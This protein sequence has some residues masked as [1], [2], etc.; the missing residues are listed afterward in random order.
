MNKQKK[1]LLIAAISI[2]VYTLLGFFVLPIVMKDQI[3]KSV[4]TLLG[5]EPTIER[6][7]FNPFSFEIEINNFVLPEVSEPANSQARLALGRLKINLDLW[8]L[9]KK[10]IRLQSFSIAD[11]SGSFRIN[12]DSG[13]NWELNTIEKISTELPSEKKSRPWILNLVKL[14]IMNTSFKFSDLTHR[15]PLELPLGPIN[16]SASHISTSLDSQSTLNKI[17]ILFAEDGSLEIEGTAGLK[18]ASANISYSFTRLPLDFLSSYLSDYSTLQLKQAFATSRGSLRYNPAGIEFNANLQIQDLD[19]IEEASKK[20]AISLGLLDIKN[21]NF[22]SRPLTAPTLLISEVMLEKLDTSLILRK[23]GTLNFKSYRRATPKKGKENNKEKKPVQYNI[24]K[25]KLTGSR[26]AYSDQQIKPGFSAQIDRLT[27]EFSPI[28]NKPQQKIQV[29]LSGRV[30][31]QGKFNAS[32]FIVSPPGRPM[33]NLDVNFANIE[34]TTFTPY[35]GKFAGYEISK[36][37]MFLNLNY[38]LTNNIIKGSNNLV[39][40]QFTLGSAVESEASDLLPVKFALAL[41]KDRDGKIKINLP[42]EGD[43][44]SPDFNFSELLWTAFKNMIFNIAAAPFDFLKGLLGGGENLDLILFESGTGILSAG[45]SEKLRSLATLLQDRPVLVV[46]VQ[47]STQP[48][49]AET[50]KKN[51]RKREISDDE[52]KK[53]GTL[54]GQLVQNEL[55]ALGIAAERIFLL[56][57]GKLESNEKLPRTSLFLKSK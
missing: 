46:E 53:L 55:V 54:R 23:D 35:S 36:G 9:L 34:L 40:D 37:K 25:I 44:N 33:L 24:Q 45:Q 12:A 31:A 47:G 16:V 15:E 39:L 4:L 2:G 26:L 38:Q 48:E 17:Q 11:T 3:K 10:E 20:S 13:T 19:L 30:E 42:V 1:I 14:N 21:L 57:A 52:I 22:T 18:P 43:M 49:D 50:L 27:G 56:A 5:A 6:L 29:R 7:N 32:G 51:L 41:L 28:S 8:P